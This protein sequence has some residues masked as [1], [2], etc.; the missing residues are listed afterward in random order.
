LAFRESRNWD[1]H[2]NAKCKDGK[3]HKHEFDS[4]S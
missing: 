4:C 3:H 2:V 1:R